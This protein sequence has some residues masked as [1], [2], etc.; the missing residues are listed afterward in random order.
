MSSRSSTDDDVVV[1]PAPAADV[2]HSNALPFAVAAVAVLQL[3][4]EQPAFAAAVAGVEAAQAAFVRVDENRAAFAFAAFVAGWF[5]LGPRVGAVV[6]ERLE[7]VA[8]LVGRS[9]WH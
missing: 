4:L 8:S 2:V 5:V 6:E 9:T 7:I 1:V 3:L